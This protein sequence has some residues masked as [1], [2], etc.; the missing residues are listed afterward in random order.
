[1]IAEKSAEAHVI[2]IKRQT[3]IIKKLIINRHFAPLG[4][5]S[6]ESLELRKSRRVD[7]N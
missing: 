6:N 5:E 3:Q 4:I 7:P 1:M 2:K